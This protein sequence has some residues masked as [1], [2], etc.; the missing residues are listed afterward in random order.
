MS[1]LLDTTIVSA[2][3]RRP[4]GLTHR[5]IQHS[6]RMAIPTVVLGE[7]YAWAY[8]RSDPTPILRAIRPC[9]SSS[10]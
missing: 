10:K 6:G 2:H 5:F 1:F 9:W 4:S 7:L 3:L 8:G